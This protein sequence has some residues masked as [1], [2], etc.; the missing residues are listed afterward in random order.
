VVLVYDG[1]YQGK[2]NRDIT[3][4]GK[5]ITVMSNGGPTRCII[6]IGGNSGHRGFLFDHNEVP[7]TSHLIGFTIRNGSDADGGGIKCVGSVNAIMG[8]P[9]IRNCVVTRCRA[10]NSGGGIH[11]HNNS[12]PLIIDCRIEDNEAGGSGGGIALHGPLR[13]G[14]PFEDRPGQPGPRPTL[15]GCVISGNASKGNGGGISIGDMCA[16]RL[17]ACQVE[18]NSSRRNGGGVA[19]DDHSNGSFNG[20]MFSRNTAERDGGAVWINGRSLPSFSTCH[21]ELNTATGDGGGIWIRDSR[22]GLTDP[23]TTARP[24]AGIPQFTRCRVAANRTGPS[25]FGGGLYA[26]GVQGSVFFNHGFIIDN[27]AGDGGG[28]YVSVSTVYLNNSV[29]NTNRAVR[30]TGQSNGNGGG[31]AVVGGALG[32]WFC[33]VYGNTA[34]N[35]GGGFYIDSGAL[36]VD[37]AI[38]WGN[39]AM[40]E[41]GAMSIGRAQNRIGRPDRRGRVYA[42]DSDIQGAHQGTIDLGGF[43]ETFDPRFLPAQQQP[44]GITYVL[45]GGS[46]PNQIVSPCKDLAGRLIPYVDGFYRFLPWPADIEGRDRMVGAAPDMGAYEIQG[47]VAG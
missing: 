24:W 46:A 45:S 11:C 10:Q 3:F 37:S 20:C 22:V 23:L 28:V 32:A 15:Q 43:N 4:N 17:T 14:T 16:P 41:P 19:I 25:G 9:T 1:I 47:S 30:V 33:T 27:V 12:I 6:D 2:G 42:A 44:G 31:A 40:S 34:E 21:I 13:T 39:D 18:Q 26:E 5:K 36:N 7:A 8:S 35:S 29:L 38:V